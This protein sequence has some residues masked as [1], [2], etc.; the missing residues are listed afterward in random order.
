MLAGLG[1]GQYPL[2]N[3]NGGKPII[4]GSDWGVIAAVF[5]GFVLNPNE[6]GGLCSVTCL[7]LDT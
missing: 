6:A 2:K 5:G 7:S 4:P 3:G 1:E